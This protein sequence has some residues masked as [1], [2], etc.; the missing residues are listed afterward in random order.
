MSRVLPIAIYTLSLGNT[1]GKWR[2]LWEFQFSVHKAWKTEWAP[3]R[4]VL[5]GNVFPTGSDYILEHGAFPKQNNSAPSSVIR[6]WDRVPGLCLSLYCK[7]QSQTVW[8]RRGISH[9]Q[10]TF[11]PPDIKP[12]GAWV[13][14]LRPPLSAKSDKAGRLVQGCAERGAPYSKIK[15]GRNI[16]RRNKGYLYAR[17]RALSFQNPITFLLY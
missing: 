9:L 2:V 14:Q 15:V 8:T 4:G 16:I 6:H 7:T 17:T 5:N 10:K 1:Q 12:A 13:T 3:W 11:I